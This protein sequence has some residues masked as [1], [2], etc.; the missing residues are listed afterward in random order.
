M[1]WALATQSSYLD[2][3]NYTIMCERVHWLVKFDAYQ[4]LIACRLDVS[5]LFD[6]K[7]ACRLVPQDD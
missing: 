6:L 3:L 1:N 2:V 5:R 7:R 4:R